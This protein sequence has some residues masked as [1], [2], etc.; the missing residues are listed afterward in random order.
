MAEQKLIGDQF[1]LLERTRT[2][3]KF[4][5]DIAAQCD[6]AGLP[7]L[8]REHDHMA[9]LCEQAIDMQLRALKSD[10]LAT[11]GNNP[12]T[13]GERE[14]IRSN[15]NEESSSKE[16]GTGQEKEVGAADAIPSAVR[17]VGPPDS[18]SVLPTTQ[19]RLP[20]SAEPE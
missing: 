9:K 18:T 4:H 7:I 19:E 1:K 2:A 8:C 13:A 16:N 20:L 10:L 14:G 11:V 17:T 12:A 5:R 15:G 6:A 3:A